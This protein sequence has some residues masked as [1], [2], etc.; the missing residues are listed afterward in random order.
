[1]K[2]LALFAVVLCFVS[3]SKKSDIVSGPPIRHVTFIWWAAPAD[4]TDTY[5]PSTSSYI[6]LMGT[7]YNYP[8]AGIYLNGHKW[9]YISVLHQGDI[10]QGQFEG[11]YS[12]L[13]GVMGANFALQVHCDCDL[14]SLVYTGDIQASKLPNGD[15][16]YG[17][18]TNNHNDVYTFVIP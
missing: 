15:V 17:T 14:S 10:V 1:M 9:E 4:S 6:S 18:N 2:K 5:T 8:F 7:K 3:C 16:V 13:G 11:T 12:H